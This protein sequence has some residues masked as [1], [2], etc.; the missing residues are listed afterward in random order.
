M[1]GQ[2]PKSRPATSRAIPPVTGSLALV[3]GPS[4][5][6]LPDG[7]QVELFGLGA[8]PASPTASQGGARAMMMPATSGPTSAG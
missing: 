6:N 8:A 7:L 4:P 1:S 3:G 2:S 5:S